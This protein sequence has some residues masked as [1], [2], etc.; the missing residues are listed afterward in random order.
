MWL[1]SLD[2]PP[3]LAVV[4]MAVTVPAPAVFPVAQPVSIL[5]P[6]RGIVLRHLKTDP[7]QVYYLYVPPGIG[8]NAPVLVAVHGISR[9]AEE[10]ARRFRR[11]ARRYGVVLVAPLFPADRFADYQRL[12]LTGQGARS[13]QAL[14]AIL[15]EVRRRTGVAGDR[16]HLFG[17]SGG[18][19]FVHR[20]AMAH[21]EQVAAVA[22]GAAGWYTFP[23][24]K[25]RFPQGLKLSRQTAVR[26]QPRQFLRI[27][28]AVFV[29]ERDVK[30]GAHRPELR[31]TGRVNT[32]Q[33]LTRLE[34]G[35]R[36][37]D[38]MRASARDRGL[39]TPYYYEVL[40]RAAHSF[41]ASVKRG[42]LGVRVFAFLFGPPPARPVD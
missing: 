19:Q 5:P 36:W 1:M 24:P 23:D 6:T 18:G 14:Q 39:S 2:T 41:T 17:Y 12:G 27:P 9:N 28:M 3:E 21:P 42:G 10:Q 16:I 20:Y 29:G 32:Q 35:D 30:R 34:R 8:P 7:G 38:A 31:Q 25:V 26:L 37:I 33:G 22:I 11:L 40:P 4:E 15:T 13:D